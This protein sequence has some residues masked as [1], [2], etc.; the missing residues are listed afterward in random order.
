VF[1][2]IFLSRSAKTIF[3]KSK[4][5][6]EPFRE[7]GDIAF[8]DWNES[9]KA[10]T[11]HQALPQLPDII[12][13][14]AAWR[15]VVVDHAALDAGDARD[16]EN[17]FDFADSTEPQLSLG[18]SPHALVRIAHQLLG[19]PALTTRDFEPVI[20][21]RDDDGQQVEAERSG[22]IGDDLR[23]LGR[24]RSGVKVEY[25]EVPYSEEERARHDELR[26]RYRMKEVQPSEVVFIS[27]RSRLDAD[28]N[29]KLRR[30]WRT[31]SEHQASRFV[32]RNDY[33]PASRFAVYDLLNPENSGYEQ[34]EL[35][36]W[37]SVLT[38]AVNALPPS[39]FQADRVYGLGVSFSDDG[40]GQLLN[41]HMSRL[42][43]LREHL[44]SLISRPQHP[45][46]T[47][48]QELLRDEKIHVEFESIGGNELAVQTTGYGIATDEPRSEA[49]K[50]AGDFD[51]LQVNATQFV[52]RPRRVLARAVYDARVKARSYLGDV[53]VLS[54]IDREE[55]EDELARRVRSLTE[56]ATTEILD[57][58]RLARLLDSENER[59][60]RHI[61]ERM[62]IR[63]ISI[64]SALVLA[65]WLGVFVP[66]LLQAAGKGAEAMQW[67]IFTVAIVVLVLAA[68][69]FAT[70]WWMRHQ[71]VVLLR[72]VNATMRRFVLRVNGGA[73]VFG[74]YLSRLA[75]YMHARAVLIGAGRLREQDR[76][77]NRQYRAV[78]ADAV[79]AIEA[80]RGIVN[81]LGQP[82]SIRRLTTGFAEFD[83]DDP[84]QISSFFRF[85]I[86][87]RQAAFNDS[88]EHVDAPYDF[89][90]KLTLE[91]VRL[92]EGTQ[93]PTAVSEERT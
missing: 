34:D 88:G 28:E 50:W 91:R 9:S 10:V 26:E 45:P 6:F 93:P 30:A 79:A 49:A 67:S 56:P 32:E 52:R 84:R 14:K 16:A 66:Y 92:F 31:E 21:Y 90:T 8:C 3:E 62:R 82:L 74:A 4:T 86:G 73:A 85:Q 58:E 39:S 22:N 46:E 19:Y 80:E 60:R 44:D 54:E 64:A 11:L 78:R 87:S 69:G 81:S 47:D 57:R 7:H 68:A 15:A 41:D 55:I 53:R 33:P 12:R 76:A 2:V 18:D 61:S 71:L 65:A 29:A 5:F 40:L 70:L 27:T 37:I 24:I 89:V 17:P 36:F 43:A 1:T 13:G 51:Q 25:H 72:S 23:H 75:T 83:I 59:V 63:T 42:T 77:R 38:L 20:S 35:R 48:V